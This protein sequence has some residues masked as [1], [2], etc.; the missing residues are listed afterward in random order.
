MG[1][2]RCITKR[3]GRS[4]LVSTSVQGVSAG[5]VVVTTG[6]TTHSGMLT[7]KATNLLGD[8]GTTG[9]AGGAAGTSSGS[10]DTGSAG[11]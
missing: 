1:Q 4:P 2:P 3:L 9:E 5:G 8:L 6:G 7:R 10:T 11:A